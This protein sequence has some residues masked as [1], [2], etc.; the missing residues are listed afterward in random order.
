MTEPGSGDSAAA[1]LIQQLRKENAKLRESR[2]QLKEKVATLEK[3]QQSL[4]EGSIVLAAD[5]AKAWEGYKA[6]NTTPEKVK[7]ALTERDTLKT[8]LAD[9]DRE[10]LVRK[11]AEDAGFVPDVLADQVKIRGLALEFRDVTEKGDDEKDIRVS[12]P[13]VR[14]ATDEKAPWEPLTAY[15]ERELKAYLPALRK[16]EGEGEATSEASRT[17][18]R[19]PA[20]TYPAQRREGAPARTAPSIKELAERKQQEIDYS[21]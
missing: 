18:A 17:P 8:T 12:R 9:R 19:S 21:M 11:A 4:P 7:E 2:R 20:V 13:H 16:A 5:E 10:A 1:G 15:A 14:P 3:N 6:L